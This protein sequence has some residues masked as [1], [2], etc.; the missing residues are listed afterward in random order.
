MTDLERLINETGNT[1]AAEA[2]M[3][4]I[5]ARMHGGIVRYMLSG[6]VPGSFL[7]AVFENDLM[8][9]A[10][11]ADAENMLLLHVY[12]RFIYNHMPTPSWGSPEKVK[13]WAKSGGMLGG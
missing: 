2:L 4:A 13:A 8:G 1:A 9:A 11:K 12:A 3:R 7:R 6:V 5:P 10:G